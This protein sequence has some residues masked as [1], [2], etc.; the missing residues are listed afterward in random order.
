MSGHG[1]RA[2]TR[3]FEQRNKGAGECATCGKLLFLSKA[4]AKRAAR[5]MPHRDGRLNAYRCGNFWHIGHLPRA[6]ARGL[7]SRDDLGRSRR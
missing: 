6:I 3:D 7:A 5:Q 2:S 4:A 1:K